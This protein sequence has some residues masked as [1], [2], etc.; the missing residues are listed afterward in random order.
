MQLYTHMLDI[1]G[2]IKLSKFPLRISTSFV[3]VILWW[4]QMSEWTESRRIHEYLSVKRSVMLQSFQLFTSLFFRKINKQEILLGN[5]TKID[6]EKK[7]KSLRCTLYTK[8]CKVTYITQKNLCFLKNQ[9]YS[10][11]NFLLTPRR[12]DG[13]PDQ[14]RAVQFVWP[15]YICHEWGGRGVRGKC[16]CSKSSIVA[17]KFHLE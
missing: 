7:A 14:R 13:P 11:F 1:G 17:S 4:E 2:Y 15:L 12:N 9:I 6:E 3:L 5:L 10:W 8:I 16:W